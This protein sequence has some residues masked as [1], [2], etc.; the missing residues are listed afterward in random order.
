[1]NSRSWG[2]RMAVKYSSYL[3]PTVIASFPLEKIQ[4]CPCSVSAEASTMQPANL[5]PFSRITIDLPPDYQNAQ[6]VSHGNPSCEGPASSPTTQSG[7]RA[8]HPGRGH[9]E[10]TCAD[11][12]DRHFAAWSPTR[13][14]PSRM[15]ND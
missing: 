5:S 11:T 10:W 6:K 1:M 15:N 2:D 12:A 4:T 7:L 13:G 8:S 14:P 3:I 9:T